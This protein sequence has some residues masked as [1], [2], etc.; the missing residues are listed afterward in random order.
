MFD[1][2]KSYLD[3]EKYYIIVMPNDIYIKNYSKIINIE[4]KEILIEIDSKIYKIV[5][6]NFILKKSIVNELKISGTVES[7]KVI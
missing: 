3:K 1:I 6:A 4:D 2:L 7:V 5:G